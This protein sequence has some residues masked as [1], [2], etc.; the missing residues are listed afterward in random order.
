MFAKSGAQAGIVLIFVKN[1]SVRL[2]LP[3]KLKMLIKL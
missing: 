1:N 2:I 3:N